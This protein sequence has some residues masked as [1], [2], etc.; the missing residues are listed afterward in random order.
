MALRLEMKARQRH[1]SQMQHWGR[2]TDDAHLSF[3]NHEHPF[4]LNMQS[5]R[6]VHRAYIHARSVDTTPLRHSLLRAN[7]YKNSF[8]SY[9]PPGCNYREYSHDSSAESSR[10]HFEGYAS[11]SKMVDTLSH[12]RKRPGTFH[13]PIFQRKKFVNHN[14]STISQRKKGSNEGFIE[15]PSSPP[16]CPK[17]ALEYSNHPS[18]MMPELRCPSTILSSWTD[19]SIAM[20]TR[21]SWNSIIALERSASSS[22]ASDELDV[23]TALCNMSET[24]QSQMKHE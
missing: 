13:T 22:S 8:T 9:S 12:N 14:R 20:Q 7:Q 16:R 4:L 15:L 19:D 1:R 11:P 6:N 5:M 10:H 3:P 23:A 17:E 2:N 21:P 24:K 18:S